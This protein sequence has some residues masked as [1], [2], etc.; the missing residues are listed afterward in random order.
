MTQPI[1]SPTKEMKYPITVCIEYEHFVG[2]DD[3]GSVWNKGTEIFTAP[4][5]GALFEWAQKDNWCNASASEI[6]TQCTVYDAVRGA[7]LH[8]DCYDNAANGC[9]TNEYPCDECG[10]SLDL[11]AAA[12]ISDADDATVT[13]W[14]SEADC[15]KYL[16]RSDYDDS[17][18]FDDD[19]EWA[20]PDVGVQ[21]CTHEDYPC[22]G[23]GLEAE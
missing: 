20:L 1:A 14:D 21:Y 9:F 3:R 16:D 13:W 15:Q 22:C 18:V 2:E 8:Y 10:E 23:C 12:W 11:E 7:S 19:V 4:R 6:A 17:P 5:P